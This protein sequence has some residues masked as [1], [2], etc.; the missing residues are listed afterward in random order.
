MATVDTALR[1]DVAS[2]EEA[3]GPE[4]VAGQGSGDTGQ[5]RATRAPARKARGRRVT[6][7]LQRALFVGPS[8]LTLLVLAAYPLVFI[9]SAA[10]TESS[11]GRPFQEFVGTANLEA[12]LD[13]AGVRGSLTLGTSYAFAEIGRAHV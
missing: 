13:S 1:G 9:A 6:G 7:R 12:A 2:T 11:L 5:H 4:A 8:V 10:F 3:G